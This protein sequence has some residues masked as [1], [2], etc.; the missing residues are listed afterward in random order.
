[1][2]DDLQAEIASLAAKKVRCSSVQEAR[3]GSFT[4]IALP[5]GGPLGLYQ[6]KHRTA[7][8][9]SQEGVSPGP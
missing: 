8:A 1:M 9:L 5:F 6:P 7:L 3:W 2:C 4:K